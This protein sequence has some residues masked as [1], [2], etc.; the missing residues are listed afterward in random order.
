MRLKAN[1]HPLRDRG[2]M[3]DKLGQ[4]D[5]YSFTMKDDK[6]G[7][8]EFG[9]MAQEINKVF[10]ELVRVDDS[11]AEQYMSVN[12]VGLIAPLIEASK[13][14]KTENE[15]L[16][17]KMATLEQRMASIEGDMNGMKAHTGYGIGKA[18]AQM[19]WLLMAAVLFG[20]TSAG[21]VLVSVKRSRK[22]G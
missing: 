20:A 8:V 2:S 10:P 1:I 7:Q 19:W 4:I 22:A 5:T 3:M 9:V 17:A 14:L 13:E 18:G 12:Y 6:N 15:D 16:K 21:A 11:T